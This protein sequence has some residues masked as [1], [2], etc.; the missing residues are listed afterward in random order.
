MTESVKKRS[1]KTVKFNRNKIQTAVTKANREVKNTNPSA[2]IMLKDDIIK[3]VDLTVE[4]LPDVKRV[5]I[6]EVQDTVE[7]TLMSMGFYDIAKSYILYRKKHQEQREATQKLMEQ[8]QLLL[9]LDAADD[10]TRR[11]NAN[12]NTNAPMGA[13][14]KAGTTAMKVFADNYIIPDE[15]VVAEKEGYCH[16]HDKDFSL[17]T[18]NCLTVD[19]LKVFHGGFNTGHGTIREPQSIRAYAALAA[20]SL[21]SS[22]NDL[23]GGQSVGAFEVAMAEGVRKS[24]RK[25][26]KEQIKQWLFFVDRSYSK[27]EMSDV[28]DQIRE[29]NCHYSD[30]T[31]KSWTDDFEKGIKE[32]RHALM[33]W[34]CI[35]ED[36]TKIY[37]LTCEAVKE[38][39]H[40]AMESFLYNMNTLHSRSGAQTVFSSINYGLD[41]TPEGRL[42]IREI[43]NVTWEGMGNG[44]TMIFPVQIFTLLEG[45]NYNPEDINYDLFKQSMK[46]SAKRLYPNYTSQ[47]S[48]YNYQYYKPD[49]YRTW[50]TSMGL[51]ALP[52]EPC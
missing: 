34:N 2:K 24:F 22:Q 43:L 40:Q 14:L 27:T 20:I 30:D 28:M 7:K 32:I 50:V 12:I 13:M 5:D 39:T 45:I 9:S 4:A 47:R 19:L 41:T 38:E 51:T 44:E 10:D 35:M 18:F 37:L 33:P 36:A 3:A 8:Y 25:T 6:E 21:Q 42:V 26:L 48:P 15:F 17:I 16:W 29:N 1:G 49:D 52:C 23:Y 11:E 46:V 31:N